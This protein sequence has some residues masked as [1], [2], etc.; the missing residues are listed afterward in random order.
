[1][2][3]AWLSVLHGNLSLA[4]YY[5]PLFWMAVP[6]ALCF[7]FREKLSAR[8]RKWA[9]IVIAFLFI[10]VYLFRMFDLT[11]DIVFFD[12]KSGLLARGFAYILHYVQEL[13]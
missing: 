1:M 3:R 13:A 7:F 5:H 6:M 8:V 9:L 11:D 4:F 10:G 2:S 12:P